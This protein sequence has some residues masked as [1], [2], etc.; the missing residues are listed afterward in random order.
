MIAR[1]AED[2]APQLT[3]FLRVE[4]FDR[5]VLGLTIAALVTQTAITALSDRDPATLVALGTAAMG[6]GLARRRRGA[7][8]ALVALSAVGAALLATDY[9]ALWTVAVMSLLSV[10]L[11]GAPAV[12]AAVLTTVPVYG[13]IVLREGEGLGSGAALTAVS[14][15]VAAAATGTALRAQARFLESMRQRA[16]DAVATRDL[17]VERGISRERLRIAQDLHDAVGHEI[18]VVGMQLGA[19]QVQ[20]GDD[21]EAARASMQ[22]AREGVQRVLR[23]TQQILDILRHDAGGDTG[24]VAD[25]R[26]IGDLVESLRAASVPVDAEL[27]GELPP[28]APPVSA[29]AYRIAQEALTNAR[30]HGSGRI[31]IAVRLEDGRLVLRVTNERPADRPTA[32]AG[33][34][35]GLVGM[36]ERAASVGG[37]L[38]IEDSPER[39]GITAALDV[40]GEGPP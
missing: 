40:R 30:R 8:L 1:P 33:S 14:L 20:L 9:I 38:D 16:L 6:V 12:P 3:W 5:V 27:P 22:G 21:P 18:A 10:T 25:I 35:Y 37:R 11:R 19:A 34:G 13:A 23:E 7:G 26:H 32:E 29:A 4:L 39:F 24:A 2:D 31:A 17:A 15:C 36:R 28:I